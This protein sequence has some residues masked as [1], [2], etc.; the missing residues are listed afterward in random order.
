[1]SLWRT[2]RVCGIN[3]G[4]GVSQTRPMMLA[5]VLLPLIAGCASPR[6]AGTDLF[7]RPLAQPASA[8]AAP[9]RQPSRTVS[10]GN[11]EDLLAGI[12]LRPLPTPAQ[13]SAAIV[14]VPDARVVV[15]RDYVVQAGDTLRGIGN[16]TGAGSE[17][18]A[19]ANA[20]TPPYMIRAGQRLTIPA[21]RYHEV[22]TGQTG[23]A[24]ARAYRVD[25]SA[26][27]AENSLEP[28]YL[29][30]LGQ[31]LRLPAGAAPSRPLT[32]EEQARAFT[33]DIDDI[34]TGSAPAT[35]VPVAPP[36]APAVGTARFAW[37]LE[38][39]ILQ[40]FGPAG[41]GRVN[42]GIK[43][44]A[45]LGAPVRAAGGGTI[46]Y[47]G[48]EVPLLG[49]LILV[50]HGNGWISAYGH[51][52]RVAVRTGQRVESGA[53]IATAGESGQV[54]EPQLHFELR[55]DRRPVDPLRQLPPR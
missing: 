48:T 19:I 37:P 43:I 39:R 55:R 53:I 1:M 4:M 36:A 13:T 24:I 40:R 25:W 2:A 28:P 20:L 44:A 30:R 11:P 21:G 23:I 32:P 7:G 6:P 49:G 8:P 38:G 18:I 31:R 52:E 15:A 54:Q 10:D 41:S 47:A 42:D 22:L 5:A 51:L 12:E 14:V 17:A 16:R 45:T 35:A 27:I 50:D 9:S 26:V 33:L 34:V 3:H 29:L 46:A